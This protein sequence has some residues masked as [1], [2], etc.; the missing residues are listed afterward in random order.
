[1]LLQVRTLVS[2][3]KMFGDTVRNKLK[4]IDVYRKV[5]NDLTEPTFSGAVI[6]VIALSCMVFLFI[7]ELV[8]YLQ[9]NLT[10]EMFVD[11]NRG[12]EQLVIN[13]DIN[14]I[15]MPCALVSLDA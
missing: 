6:S 1:M 12:D 11:I 8:A 7:T 3:N 13:M 4:K 5:P 15:R 2:L 14:L 10:S 9:I